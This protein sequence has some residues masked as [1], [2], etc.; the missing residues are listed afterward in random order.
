MTVPRVGRR[1]TGK[2][3]LF[4]FLFSRSTFDPDD[5]G[6]PG[7][8]VDVAEFGAV[9]IV[10]QN[11][12]FKVLPVGLDR[13]LEGVLNLENHTIKPFALLFWH[14]PHDELLH[15]DPFG[16]IG[17]F[18]P[19]REFLKYGEKSDSVIF[20]VVVN[21]DSMEEIS[22]RETS[23]RDSRS[24]GS[25]E[26]IR[27]A[28]SSHRS[29]RLPSAAWPKTLVTFSASLVISFLTLSTFSIRFNTDS[30]AILPS[31]RPVRLM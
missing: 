23:M 20:S 25:E 26:K 7:F 22:W 17:F 13:R 16:L 29:K 24:S 19:K 3:I 30:I 18:P 6:D 11:S 2:D 12:P 9:L 5:Q 15:E 1:G 10:Q 27:S 14:G 28:M 4:P 21:I 31:F 8:V